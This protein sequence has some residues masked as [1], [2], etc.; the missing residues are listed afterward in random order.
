MRW[1]VDAQLPPALAGL[2]VGQGHQAEHVEEVGLRDASDNSI[3]EYA[4]D[5]AA[6]IITK[7][8][9][10]QNRLLVAREAPLVVWIRIGNCSRRYLLQ[11]FEPLLPGIVERIDEGEKLIEVR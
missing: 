1:I 4:L 10:F 7:D 6:V 5:N 3:W 8:E 11:W 9:D 2:L